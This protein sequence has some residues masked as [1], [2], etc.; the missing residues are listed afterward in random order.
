LYARSFH[1]HHRYEP[2]WVGLNLSPFFSVIGIGINLVRPFR[3]TGALADPIAALSPTLW[4]K[5]DALTGAYADED[6]VDAWPDSSGNGN[7]AAQGT[8]AAM[9]TYHASGGSNGMPFV[10]FDGTDDTL[11]FGEESL[12]GDFTL[13]VVARAFGGFFMALGGATDGSCFCPFPGAGLVLLRNSVDAD[14]ANTSA[15]GLDGWCVLT[16][17]R[18]GTAV[19][20]YQNGNA[21]APSSLSGVVNLNNMG[22]RDITQ[23][24]AGALTDALIFRRVLAPSEL[25]ILHSAL[26]TKYRF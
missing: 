26:I 15:S 6:V 18:T 21:L 2:S 22:R 8:F 1:W 5:A 10:S 3:G 14:T 7:D 19:A 17:T 16:A 13:C 12:T 20:M 25:S 4:L 11:L 24:G 9:P 23:Y